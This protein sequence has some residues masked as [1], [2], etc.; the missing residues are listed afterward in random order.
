MLDSVRTLVIW[1]ISLLL[2][3][4]SFS[5]IQ[6]GGFIILLI[7]MCV[8]NDIVIRPIINKY[9]SRGAENEP[10]LNAEE[11]ESQIIS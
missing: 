11:E 6:L 2:Q 4:E 3:W 9:V 7:G 5:F 1:I 8:Y 10:I